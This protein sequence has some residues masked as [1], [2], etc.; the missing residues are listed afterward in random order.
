MGVGVSI[1]AA[2]NT[3][4]G[5]IDAATIV[6]GAGFSPPPSPCIGRNR[7]IRHYPPADV[8]SSSTA[9]PNLSCDGWCRQNVSAMRTRMTTP[10]P[11]TRS[12]QRAA[13]Q[14]PLC[15]AAPAIPQGYRHHQQTAFQ[16][17][18]PVELYRH[19]YPGLLSN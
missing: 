5:R 19:R 3:A 1:S 8:G 13:D 11:A 7:R 2:A 4:G 15:V 9:Y 16:F 18:C 14:V 12:V 17:P 6:V 10:V